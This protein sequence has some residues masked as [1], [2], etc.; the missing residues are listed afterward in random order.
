MESTRRSTSADDLREG[1]GACANA[2]T[3][4][5]TINDK[6]TIEQSP[7]IVFSFGLALTVTE[8]AVKI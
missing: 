1:A 2:E 8:M 6:Q 7:R 3:T 5:E 4:V